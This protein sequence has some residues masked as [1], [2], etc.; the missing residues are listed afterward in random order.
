M[1]YTDTK[2][3]PTEQAFF[4]LT[5]TSIQAAFAQ[6]SGQPYP[7]FLAHPL[8]VPTDEATMESQLGSCAQ[9]QIEWKWDGIRAQLIKRD[10]QWWLWS[11]GEE[12]ITEGFPDLAPLANALPDGTVID[13]EL[14]AWDNARQVPLPFGKLQQRIA[15]KVLTTKLLSEVPTLLIAYDILELKGN[16]IRTL[17]QIK[18]RGLLE[19]IAKVVPNLRLSEIVQESSWQALRT[20]REA[21]RLRGVEGFML[22]ANDA[23][24]GVGRTK[25]DGVWWKWKIDPLTVD[26]VLIYAQRGH[27][28]RASLYTDY[29]FAVW[30]GETLVPFAK[31]YSGLTD[32]EFKRVDEVIRKTTID[33][34]GPVRSVTPTLV[35]ELG[36][37]GIQASPRHK[38]GIAVRFPRILRWREDKQVK[39]ADSL[40]TLRAFLE[41][42]AG[43]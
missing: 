11:R 20:L 4:R 26:C 28:R 34:F 41:V 13:G 5:D 7:F 22:K 43:K 36:F 42:N 19:D 21:S 31:A 30:Q 29:T 38:S 9:W 17:P 8:L 6:I 25:A 23:K 12:L 15:R 40:N 27:G 16:D 10:G 32:A 3:Q 33:K 2:A 1:G 35:F 24:Y 18:R 37:E 14:V 39:D